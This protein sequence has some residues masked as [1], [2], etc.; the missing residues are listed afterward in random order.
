[1]TKVIRTFRIEKIDLDWWEAKAKRDGLSLSE[2]I[3]R[4]CN[5]DETPLLSKER[6]DEILVKDPTRQKAKTCSHGKTKGFHCWQCGG[7]A[8]VEG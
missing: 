7:L 2:W 3:R 8:K 1:M 4:R 5:A 6:V